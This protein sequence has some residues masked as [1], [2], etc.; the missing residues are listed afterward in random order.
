MS[1]FAN[2]VPPCGSFVSWLNG[3]FFP[4]P[5][6]FWILA[7][8]MLV[9]CL[10]SYKSHQLTRSGIVLEFLLGM[11]IT[12]P[13]GFGGLATILYFFIMAAVVGRC[14]KRM[15]TGF[16]GM[17]KKGSCRD[18]VQVF[19]NGGLALICSLCYAWQQNPAFLVM[20]GASVAEASA[21]TTAGDI[22]VLSAQTPV[23]ILTWKPMPKGQSGAVT[24]QGLLASLVASFLVA[25]VWQSCFLFPS[26]DA[27]RQLAIVTACG[28]VG[29]A[30]DS[31]LGATCQA[32]YYDP[33][34][35][36]LTERERDG[37]G[38]PLERTRG[39]PWMDNDMVNFLSGLF[40]SLLA[41]WV[42]TL[43]SH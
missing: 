14:S 15:R 32:I 25:L 12:W 19:A 5:F 33:E 9:I 20:F 18:G 7:V 21:D 26:A 38:R 29:A 27:L 30:F 8:L 6:S 34:R 22:G 39:I 13:L 36:G 31:F 16:A 41:G 42:F 2:L 24:L 35:G 23:S 10:L 17:E 40:A 37:Q 11:G 1:R 4:L 28:F 43:L 3:R